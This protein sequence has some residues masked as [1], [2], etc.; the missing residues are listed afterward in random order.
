M[1]TATAT[2]T[3]QELEMNVLKSKI[4]ELQSALF[5]TESVSLVK[6]PTHVISDVEVDAEGRIWFAVPRPAMHIDAFEK[7][8]PAKLD[9]FRK[10]KDFF[11]KVRGTA[12]LLTDAKTINSYESVSAD[13]RKK[14]SEEGSM[15][16]MVKI[17][18]TDLVD[19][20]P[21]SAQSW[22]Q[23]SRSHLSSWFF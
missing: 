18:K 11:V 4:L 12:V 13:M 10:G 14:M 16:I 22:L 2:P 3:A 1:T 8:V 7:E 15:G 17:E 20:S 9:F 23:S 21:K 6:L 19:N 5:Y